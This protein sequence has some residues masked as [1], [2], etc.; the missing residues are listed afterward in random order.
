MDSFNYTIVSHSPGHR[1]VISTMS[2]FFFFLLK[3]YRTLGRLDEEINARTS[4]RNAS[5]NIWTNGFCACVMFCNK[6]KPSL[7]ILFQHRSEISTRTT[8]YCRRELLLMAPTDIH[9]RPTKPRAKKNTKISLL[10]AFIMHPSTRSIYLFYQFKSFF[11]LS[12]FSMIPFSAI[13]HKW[14]S[15]GRTAGLLLIS[16]NI[17]DGAD[18]KKRKKKPPKDCRHQHTIA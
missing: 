5:V 16:K 17:D 8:A 9:S 11:F 14:N 3:I 1:R 10:D 13:S 2:F 12:I 6:K 18:K 4:R 15:V 7:Y